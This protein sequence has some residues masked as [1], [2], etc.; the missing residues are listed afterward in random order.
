[1]PTIK[2]SRVI[3]LKAALIQPFRIS[4]GS[5][6]TLDNFLIHF[7][8]DN[9]IA[10]LGEAAVA[11]HITGETLAG[12][13]RGLRQA[14]KLIRNR[15]LKEYRRI[16]A[17]LHEAFPKNPAIIAAVETA[18]LDALTRHRGKPLWRIFGPSCHSLKSDITIV[19]S[20]LK[21]SRDS[22]KRFYANG[23]RSFKVKIGNNMDRDI[24]RLL[25]F[26]D[27]APRCPVIVDANQGYSA[28]EMIHFVKALRK[29]GGRVDLLEQ[30]VAVDDWEGLHEVESKTRVAVCADESARS[31]KDVRRIIK[32]KLCRVV[33]IKIMKTGLLH[34]LRIARMCRKHGLDVMIGGMMESSI[35]M[36]ASAHL[37][38]GFGG[39][40]YI[41]LDTPFFIKG[42]IAKHPYL[43]SDGHYDLRSI[44]AG[45]GLQ[46]DQLHD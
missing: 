33:N 21:E 7:V 9:G 2:K 19:L 8:C 40:K 1:M 44:A 29:H 6:Q 25:L 37:A 43:S 11:T 4:L 45:I 27:L 34:G 32:Y 31:L 23:F 35:A 36:T 39:I 10:G 13:Q 16:S 22:I 46:R 3:P 12:T 5:H 28:E 24:K 17:E 30:P 26:K 38:A 18:L 15:D 42:A 20:N 14:A 41:D